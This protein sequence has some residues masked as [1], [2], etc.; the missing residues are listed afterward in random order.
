MRLATKAENSALVVLRAALYFT[1]SSS[2]PFSVVSDAVR[3]SEYLSRLAADLIR[4]FACW[5]C[6]YCWD[7]CAYLSEPYAAPNWS[8]PPTDCLLNLNLRSTALYNFF[9]A[10]Q[11]FSCLLRS[12]QIFQLDRN[13][14]STEWRSSQ[15]GGVCI[16]L[17]VCPLAWIVSAHPWLCWCIWGC[18]PFPYGSSEF[19]FALPTYRGHGGHCIK[20][21]S[22]LGVQTVPQRCR[23]WLVP[24]IRRPLY[25]LQPQG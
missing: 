24:V 17:W 6:W 23:T 4:P 15:W 11:S 7:W 21:S 2:T 22:G 12:S 8:W 5:D 9:Q 20:F 16:P 10:F 19:S 14:H 3:E 18:P 25:L 13:S 1:N